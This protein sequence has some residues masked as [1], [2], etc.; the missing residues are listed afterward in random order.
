MGKYKERCLKE[1]SKDNSLHCI[2]IKD[3]AV[4]DLRD[5]EVGSLVEI[6]HINS[7][8]KD[9]KEIRNSI[10]EIYSKKI[11][12]RINGN[13]FDF[14]CGVKGY[15]LVIDI[16]SYI[17]E[18]QAHNVKVGI[19]MA[20]KKGKQIG[21]RK[22]SVEDLPEAF[23]LNY[24]SYKEGLITKVEFAEMCLCSRPTLNSWIKCFESANVD[25]CQKIQKL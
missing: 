23:L 21:R 17:I 8:G 20:R 16:L 15:L 4:I 10:R 5:I 18:Q 12:L 14:S 3:R 2:K 19:E 25:K 1:S 6:E 13:T 7:L 24:G 9:I 22:L 11:S